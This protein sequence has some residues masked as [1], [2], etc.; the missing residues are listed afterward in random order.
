LIFQ[1]FIPILDQSLNHDLKAQL[2]KPFAPVGSF[3][4]LVLCDP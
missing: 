2:A 1:I 3:P 4:R